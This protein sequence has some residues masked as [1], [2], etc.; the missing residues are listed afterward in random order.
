MKKKLI[1]TAAVFCSLLA[2]VW[3]VGRV[4]GMLLF[5]SIPTPV[6]MPKINPGDR[7]ISSNIKE[8]K[9]YDFIIFTSSYSDS[10]NGSYT[11]SYEK[12]SRYL[13]RLCGVN[14]DNLEMKNGLLYVN[15]KY[16]DS[17][18]NLNNV[19]K[20][21]STELNSIEQ[22]DMLA[23]EAAG[24][25]QMISNDSAMITLN[26]A[27]LKKYASTIKPIQFIMPYS[28]NGPFKWNNKN[29]FWSTDNFGPL[30]IP[31]GCYFVLG[32]NRHNAMDS[33]YI[34]FVKKE[35]IKGVVLNK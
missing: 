31:T 33:R 9:P 11:E 3:I 4:T 29:N 18:L 32:D 12:G 27:L 34:G 8:P 25:M 22:E 30:K 10:V 1:I 2:A 7:V 19:Y 24:G 5:F 28:K 23:V 16:F 13:Y 21:S 14:G 15:N 35:D 20:I 26:N 17:G 6:N